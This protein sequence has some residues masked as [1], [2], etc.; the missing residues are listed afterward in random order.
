MFSFCFDEL[1]IDVRWGVE[2]S[3][4]YYVGL[5]ICFEL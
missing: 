2:V 1:S 4:D 5:S 3:Y